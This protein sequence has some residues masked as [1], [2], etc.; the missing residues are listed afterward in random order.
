MTAP[1]HKIVDLIIRFA[2]QISPEV[3]LGNTQIGS[4]PIDVKRTI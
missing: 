3:G 1:H 4:G 2:A